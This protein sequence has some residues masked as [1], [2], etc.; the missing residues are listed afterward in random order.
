V[1]PGCPAEVKDV[2][3]AADAQLYKAKSA[4]RDRVCAQTLDAAAATAAE[5]APAQNG[6]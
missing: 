5:Q 1:P 2:L 3:R 6:A 4:G